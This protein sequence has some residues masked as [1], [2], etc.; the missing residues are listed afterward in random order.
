MGLAWILPVLLL[1]CAG[2]SEAPP[3]APMPPLPPAPCAAERTF[4]IRILSL[5]PGETHVMVWGCRPI[6]N[7]GGGPTRCSIV[8]LGPVRVGTLRLRYVD[9]EGVERTVERPGPDDLPASKAGLC[10]EHRGW[11]VTGRLHE[12]RLLLSA[13]DLLWNEEPEASIRAYQRLEA[14]Y[15]EFLELLGSPLRI[16]RRAEQGD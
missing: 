15:G 5:E 14:E 4:S 8:P 7:P 9:E 2:L 11:A 12:A 3:A 1:G 10:G 6:R 16:R 13:A